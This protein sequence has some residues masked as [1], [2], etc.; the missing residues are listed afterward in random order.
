[1]SQGTGRGAAA[2]AAVPVP[3]IAVDG[4]GGTGK[5]ELCSRLAHWLDWHCLDSGLLYRALALHSARRAL[6]ASAGDELARLAEDME[7]RFD[8]L[9]PGGVWLQG[10][11]VQAE[12]RSEECAGRA[13]QIAALPEVRRALLGRHLAF[14]RPPGLVADGRDV[15]TVVFPDAGLKIFLRAT[16]A[17]RARRRHK[18]LKEWEGCASVSELAAEISRRD[19]RDAERQVAP[20]APAPGA[21]IIDSSDESAE[22][23]FRRVAALVADRFDIPPL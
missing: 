16:L 19:E 10:S 4:A 22:Q 9:H 13:S 1:M 5:S 23:V 15:G 3:V 2:E 6:P 11:W 20:L 12:L 21:V 8:A 7:L 14:R 17:E 18:Q